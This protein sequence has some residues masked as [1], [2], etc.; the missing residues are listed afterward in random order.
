MLIYK[1]PRQQQFLRD[2]RGYVVSPPTAVAET[3]AEEK[4]TV[5]RFCLIAAR[6]GCCFASILLAIFLSLWILNYPAIVHAY[7]IAAPS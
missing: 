1:P 3:P 6:A 4:Y 2:K 7:T 5:T